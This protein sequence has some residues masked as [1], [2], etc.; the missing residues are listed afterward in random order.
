MLSLFSAIS[1]HASLSSPRNHGIY[2]S[3]AIKIWGT[4][5]YSI[6]LMLVSLPAMIITYRSIIT[7][8]QLPHFRSF[9]SLRVLLTPTE[10]RKP[11]ILYLTRT[12]TPGAELLYISYAVVAIYY[13]LFL[14]WMIQ[15]PRTFLL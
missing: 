1:P 13:P 7:P 5:L 6:F 12:R 15:C 14:M 8:Y 11:W 9:H 3:P 10:R 4:L 2:N